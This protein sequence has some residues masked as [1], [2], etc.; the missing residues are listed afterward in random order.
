MSSYR[1]I[2]SNY[3]I[4]DPSGFSRFINSQ[5]HHIRWVDDN[6]TDY[7]TKVLEYVEDEDLPLVKD[8]PN[9]PTI[10]RVWQYVVPSDNPELSNNGGSYAYLHR[11]EEWTGWDNDNLNG[12]YLVTNHLY[13]SDFE[14]QGWSTDRFASSD[15]AWKYIEKFKVPV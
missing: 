6:E 3:L 12:F 15:D 13:D 1:T 11:V 8:N 7:L 9:P 10:N 14:E 5:G 4:K 2:N